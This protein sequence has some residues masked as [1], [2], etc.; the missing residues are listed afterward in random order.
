MNNILS[1]ISFVGLVCLA[2]ADEP[3]PATGQ[4]STLSQVSSDV[5]QNSYVPSAIYQASD[6]ASVC[7]RKLFITLNKIL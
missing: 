5:P 2:R 6:T 7:A 3:Y 4:Q 1:V